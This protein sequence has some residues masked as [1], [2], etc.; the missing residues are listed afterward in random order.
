MN[1]SNQSNKNKKTKISKT[2]KTFDINLKQTTQQRQHYMIFKIT[3][4]GHATGTNCLTCTFSHPKHFGQS[5]LV[6][7]QATCTSTAQ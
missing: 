6:V 5:L 2:M 4:H 3:V 7:A 1:S